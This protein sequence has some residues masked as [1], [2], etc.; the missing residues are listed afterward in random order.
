PACKR[1]FDFLAQGLQ[2]YIR[3]PLAS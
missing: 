2:A 1:V 3:G